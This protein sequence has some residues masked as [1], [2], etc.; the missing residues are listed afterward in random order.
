MTKTQHELQKLVSR[1]N[2][3]GPSTELTPE[4]RWG[5]CQSTYSTEA[6]FTGNA[7]QQWPPSFK[8][9]WQ[10]QRTQQRKRLPN[11]SWVS[12]PNLIPWNKW[13]GSGLL[14]LR[15]LPFYVNTREGWNSQ[16]QDTS[17]LHV[18]TALAKICDSLM[19]TEQGCLPSSLSVNCTEMWL[20]DSFSI[21]ERVSWCSQ[22]MEM[23]STHWPPSL[24]SPLTHWSPNG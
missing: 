9:T 17:F 16:G 23:N 15:S 13:W 24:P 10:I 21:A 22:K 2:T 19:V 18:D 6:T 1:L 5:Q 11:S 3:A 20:S 14:V 7:P 4:P 8:A 12:E